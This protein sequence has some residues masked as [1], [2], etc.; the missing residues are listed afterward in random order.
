MYGTGFMKPN[1]GH[2]IFEIA[3]RY[4]DEDA[5]STLKYEVG[6]WERIWTEDKNLGIISILFKSQSTSRDTLT[7]R[8]NCRVRKEEP[9]LNS[10]ALVRDQE[11]QEK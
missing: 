6:L 10:G 9:G 8:V 5:K 7:E 1:L 2:F 3:L 11:G 4:P